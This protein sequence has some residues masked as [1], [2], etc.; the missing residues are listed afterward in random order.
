[1]FAYARVSTTEQGKNTSL[2]DQQN[3]ITA[4]AKTLGRKV[5]QFYVEAESGAGNA[6]KKRDQIH[7]LLKEARRGDLVL[8]YALDRWSR[9]IIF[10]HQSTRDLRAR[11]V[12]ISSSSTTSTRAPTR[13]RCSSGTWRLEPRPNTAGSNCA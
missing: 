2:Q 1:M 7:A 4:Y 13:A 10:T 8:C 6:P 9:D 11:G 3:A 12:S 5:T